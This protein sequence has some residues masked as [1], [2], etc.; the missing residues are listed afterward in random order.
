M[1]NGKWLKT[2]G[3][4]LLEF[5]LS[6]ETLVFG[7]DKALAYNGIP[8]GL[9]GNAGVAAESPAKAHSSHHSSAS[10]WAPSPSTAV[11]GRRRSCRSGTQP[12][13]SAP[14]PQRSPASA[15]SA[16]TA[17]ALRFAMR[18]RQWALAAL[19]TVT[20]AA[21]RLCTT[22]NASRC[23]CTAAA[24]PHMRRRSSFRA[25]AAAAAVTAPRK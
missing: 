15:P 1:Q 19:G 16:A 20:A 12:L 7:K 9:A 2:Y 23:G 22:S 13:V 24:R 6:N 18:T 11:Q 4:G 8:T 21:G 3:P 5:D 25:A 17:T 14:V 10:S